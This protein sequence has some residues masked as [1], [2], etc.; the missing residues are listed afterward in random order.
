MDPDG[1][2]A[3]SPLL[4]RSCRRMLASA[5]DRDALVG[6]ADR[7]ASGPFPPGTAGHLDDAGFP[8][9]DPT[10]ARELVA[11]CLAD[12]ETER[13]EIEFATAAD[14]AAVADVEQLV[15]GWRR[16]LGPA[17]DVR[18]DVVD[19]G[20]LGPRALLGDV[21]ALLWRNHAGLD[22][23]R[24]FLWWWSGAAAP[25]GE[26]AFN[27]GRFQDPVIDQQLVILRQSDDPEV[28]RDAAASINRAFGDNVWNLWL[29][30]T[31][32]SVASRPEVLDLTLA[33]LPD[34]TARIPLIA[35]VHSL[36]EARCSDTC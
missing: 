12:A 32:W 30:W 5:T 16:V 24:Q 1:R 7:V 18:V 17:L 9:F 15:A 4:H 21:Q 22:P 14:P 25:I 34:G 35:G 31:Q 2:N 28:R 20:S 23:D 3:A 13:V 33:T 10:A 8:G 29:D 19:D 26:V 27:V 36:A 6:E 11:D